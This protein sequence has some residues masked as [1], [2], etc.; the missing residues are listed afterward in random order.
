MAVI[1]VVIITVATMILV[2]KM[3][4]GLKGRPLSSFCILTYS[5]KNGRIYLRKRVGDL[6]C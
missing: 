1:T 3:K 4:K 5:F 6:I 2:A